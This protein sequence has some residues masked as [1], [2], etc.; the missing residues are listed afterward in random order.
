MTD[1]AQDRPARVEVG[2]PEILS[3]GFRAYERYNIALL[4][5]DGACGSQTRD[6]IRAGN[7]VGVLGYDP[8]R[9]R[10]VLIRQ[11]RFGAHLARGRGAMVEIVA[12]MVEAGESF[13]AAALRE[14]REEIGVVPHVLVP[15]MGYM[16]SPGVSDEYAE[17][18]LG[19]L[20]A[21]DLPEQAG[22]PEEAE[23]THPFSVS[24]DEAIAAVAGRRVINGYVIAAVQWL[25]L[26]R[27]RLPALLAAACP[28]PDGAP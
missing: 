13:E 27:A 7:V 11:F 18:Y 8:A 4:D 22:A 2:R 6:L 16:P 28:P 23:R 20:D 24:V 25:A 21:G 1:G 3:R 5:E 15:M 9:D 12:G 14:C 19:I 17:L 10:V 26:N